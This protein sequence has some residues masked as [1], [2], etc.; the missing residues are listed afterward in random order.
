MEKLILIGSIIAVF[1]LIVASF[2]SLIALES[3]DDDL[4]F[5]VSTD[6]D[7]Y[8][9]MGL[10]GKHV[11]VTLTLK[12]NGDTDKTLNFPSGRQFDFLVTTRFGRPIYIFSEDKLYIQMF[13]NVTVPTGGNVSWTLNW[14][15]LGHILLGITPFRL[16]PP[17]RYKI[18]GIIPSIERR[19]VDTTEILIE[20]YR[21]L[22]LYM[23][24]PR[25]YSI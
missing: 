12:N 8:I 22:F 10:G 25:L 3:D 2:P 23:F 16:V 15:Q 5:I 20:G 19:Y 13:T 9:W 18:I 21:H 7:V 4:E 17:G 11:E 24:F 14:Y 6:K 1:I